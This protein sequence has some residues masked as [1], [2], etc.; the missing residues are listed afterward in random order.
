MALLGNQAA[1]EKTNDNLSV[2]RSRSTHSEMV[3]QFSTELDIWWGLV[4]GLATGAGIL[5]VRFNRL[6]KRVDLDTLLTR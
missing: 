1:T 4:I 6:L 3:G 5:L 2:W